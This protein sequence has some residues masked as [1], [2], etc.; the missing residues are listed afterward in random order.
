MASN[1]K[2]KEGKGK[3]RVIKTSGREKTTTYGGTKK[4]ILGKEKAGTTVKKTSSGGL[5]QIGKFR[6]EKAA[7][8]IG[9]LPAVLGYGMLASRKQKP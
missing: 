3:D 7:T 8:A 2:L 5:G 9:G 6:D 1:P 4:N